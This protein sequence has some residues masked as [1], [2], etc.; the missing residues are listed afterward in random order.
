[1]MALVPLLAGAK[2]PRRVPLLLIPMMTGP[3]GTGA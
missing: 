2:L 1:M 3:A